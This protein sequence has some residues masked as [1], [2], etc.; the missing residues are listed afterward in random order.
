[1]SAALTACGCCDGMGR[2]P[3][4]RSGSQACPDCAGMGTVETYNGWRNRATWAAWME[5]NNS[6]DLYW[7]MRDYARR[8]MNNKVQ[9]SYDQFIRLLEMEE[10]PMQTD[11]LRFGH[12]TISRAQLDEALREEIS[13]IKRFG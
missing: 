8:C 9:P 10:T 5:I 11:G 7:L 3:V 4:G 13:E 6:R 1:V 2:L 12:P